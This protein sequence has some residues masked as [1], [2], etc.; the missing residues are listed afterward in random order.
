MKKLK[1]ILSVSLC[2]GLL[3]MSAVSATS[4]VGYKLPAR[5]GNNYTG[6]HSKTKADANI[7]NTLEN[8]EKTDTVTFWA[9]NSTKTQISND[10]DQKKGSVA[11]IRFTT[12]GYAK[13]GKEVKL[14]MENANWKLNTTAFCAG[15]VN[16]K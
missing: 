9:A 1:R 4:Y 12:S 16:F 5:Q 6:T 3:S 15:S 11:T 14:G 2:V 10:Y 8:V 7:V 13:K